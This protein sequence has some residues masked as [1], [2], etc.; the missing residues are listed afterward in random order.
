MSQL[1]QQV[2]RRYTQGRS[3]QVRAV[4]RFEHLALEAKP[5]V[6]ENTDP[7]RWRQMEQQV[8]RLAG[9]EIRTEVMVQRPNRLFLEERSA[10]G[11]F[12][13]VCDGRTWQAQLQDGEV[14]KTPA[15]GTLSQMA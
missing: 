10:F 12:R 8:K 7:A 1:A 13:S 4:A 14:I 3:L 9:Q 5:S 2:W 11:W 6:Y 15:P